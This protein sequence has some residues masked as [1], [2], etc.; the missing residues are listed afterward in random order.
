MIHPFDQ[1]GAIIPSWKAVGGAHCVA[2]LQTVNP[3]SVIYPIPSSFGAKQAF[4]TDSST[5]SRFGSRS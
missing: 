5:F 3:E 4:R 1:C 2:A